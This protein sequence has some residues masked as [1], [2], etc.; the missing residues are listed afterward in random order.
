MWSRSVTVYHM[1]FQEVPTVGESEH[2]GAAKVKEST[3]EQQRF[4]WAEIKFALKR[5]Y[6]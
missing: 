5:L 2:H 4:D 1:M 6:A 3:S